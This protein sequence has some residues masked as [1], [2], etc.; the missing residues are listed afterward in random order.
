MNQRFGVTSAAA[1]RASASRKQ[2]GLVASKVAVWT[3][4]WLRMPRTVSSTPVALQGLAPTRRTPPA[5]PEVTAAPRVIVMHS[6]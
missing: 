5:Y 2:A 6:Q 4:T 1:A 3:P